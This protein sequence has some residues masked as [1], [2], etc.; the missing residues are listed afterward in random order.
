MIID[1]VSG[2]V[3]RR[4]SCRLLAAALCWIVSA[5]ALGNGETVLLQ[6]TTS[7]RNSGLYDYL[8][9]QLQAET[10]I[11]ANVVAVGTGQAIRNA[12]N[13]DADILLVHAQNAEEQFVADG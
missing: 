6:S 10:G 5:P 8:L 12:R 11:T 9:P 7:T 3:E 1:S 4:V 13:C 2:G